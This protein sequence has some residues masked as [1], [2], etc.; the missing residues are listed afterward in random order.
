MNEIISSYRTNYL[1][2]Q[3]DWVLRIFCRNPQTILFL[4]H[5]W[6]LIIGEKLQPAGFLIRVQ[7]HLKKDHGYFIRHTNLKGPTGQIRSARE[8]STIR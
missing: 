1:E 7:K 6:T 5:V 3:K 8:Y 2:D 4:Q